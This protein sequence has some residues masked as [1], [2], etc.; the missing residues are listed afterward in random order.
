MTDFILFYLIMS[1]VG[2]SQKQIPHSYVFSFFSMF[3]GAEDLNSGNNIQ[4]TF[5]KQKVIKI[6][7]DRT[8]PLGW[9]LSI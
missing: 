4:N 6:N 8:C 7:A 5:H 2:F 3:R 9:L 1:E